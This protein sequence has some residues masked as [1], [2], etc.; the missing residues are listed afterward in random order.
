MPTAD[1]EPPS[2]ELLLET[3]D[4]AFGGEPDDG[5]RGSWRPGRAF[6]LDWARH[7]LGATLEADAPFAR[8][9][10]SVRL[11]GEE[12]MRALNRGW[13]DRDAPTNVLSFPSGL[14]VLTGGDAGECGL[15]VLGDLALCPSVIAAEARAQGKRPSDHWAHL[16]VHGVLHLRGLDHEE[17]DEALIMETLETRLLSARDRPDPYAF[18][19]DAGLRTAVRAD[20]AGSGPADASPP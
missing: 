9:E 4:D 15:L 17:R 6:L 11:V 16:V 1:P 2:L 18:V 10:L 12:S 13:R 5:P 20:A 19:A 8:A 7:A 3:D 14:P